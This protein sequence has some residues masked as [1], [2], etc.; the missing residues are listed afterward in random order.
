ME[1]FCDAPAADLVPATLGAP[2]P[3]VPADGPGV[4]AHV[5]AIQR[6]EFGLPIAAADQADLLDVPAHYQRG[7]GGFW[8]A[9]AGA[10]IGGTIG[11]L[12]I[13][14]GHG[15]LRKM[16]VAAAARGRTTGLAAALLDMLVGHARHAGLHTLWLGTTD[17]F[18]AAQRF[19]EKHGFAPVPPEA[20]PASFPRMAVDT[21]F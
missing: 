1:T 8:V 5:L 10:G 11:L 18:V 9:P 17:A 16:F 6:E 4:L 21:R 2:R 15:A 14:G 19:Y 13:S 3:Y 7:A 20:L 12:D